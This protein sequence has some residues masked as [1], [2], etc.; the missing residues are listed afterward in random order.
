MH[1]SLGE[2]KVRLR[3]DEMESSD[4][5]KLRKVSLEEFSREQQ[6]PEIEAVLGMLN[7][8]S[9]MQCHTA[10][11]EQTGIWIDELVPVFQRLDAA[12]AFKELPA[13]VR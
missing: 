4:T 2:S 1:R 11:R 8:G 5:P 6:T 7:G 3:E 10:I 13:D 9:F 12:L